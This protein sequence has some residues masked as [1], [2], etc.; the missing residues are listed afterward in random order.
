MGEIGKQSVELARYIQSHFPQTTPGDHGEILQYY[1][2]GSLATNLLSQAREV[3]LLDQAALPKVVALSSRLIP[4]S[5]RTKLAKFAR[6]VGDIDMVSAAGRLEA[7]PESV[8]IPLSQTPQGFETAL[9]LQSNQNEINLD[10]VRTYTPPQVV[11]V[12]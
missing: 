5:T 1:F 4:T 6:P 10:Y 12:Q 11:R 7:K 3:V 9:K 2:G 8:T